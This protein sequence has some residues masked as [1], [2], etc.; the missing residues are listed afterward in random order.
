KGIRGRRRAGWRRSGGS[1]RLDLGPRSG[2]TP[3]AQGGSS[4]L[5]FARV[6]AGACTSSAGLPLRQ[7]PPGE[8]IPA[9][10]VTKHCPCDRLL[11]HEPYPEGQAVRAAASVGLLLICL[12]VAG[13]HSSGKKAP[14]AAAAP[15]PS[16]GSRNWAT[17]PEATG[18]G[19]VQ[20]A[21][22]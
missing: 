21:S 14:A 4:L 20:Q 1:V 6:L 22:Y 16:T 3:R 12:G 7:A 9:N 2:N 19:P 5:L 18:R 13:C 10:P 8:R 15:A 11:D 17:Q